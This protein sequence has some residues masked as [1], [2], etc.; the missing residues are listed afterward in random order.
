M[1]GQQLFQN[2]SLRHIAREAV[3]ENTFRIFGNGVVN[4]FDDNVVA[5]QSAS[6]HDAFDTLAQF[7]LVGD[8]FTQQIASRD[9]VQIVF[10]DQKVRLSALAGTGSPK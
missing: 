5:D 3:E 7:C 6:I 1:F 9:M 4:H 8:F 10:F 2:F